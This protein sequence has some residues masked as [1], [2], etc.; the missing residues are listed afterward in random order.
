MLAFGNLPQYDGWE[1]I[2]IALYTHKWY[3]CV[4]FVYRLNVLKS[5]SSIQNDNTCNTST[6]TKDVTSRV[7]INHT[8]G[9]N[10]NSQLIS[11]TCIFTK[12]IYFYFYNGAYQ[13]STAF[14]IWL[15][16]PPYLQ[17]LLVTTHTIFSIFYRV[18]YL[19]K[20]MH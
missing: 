8:H 5:W 3:Y 2:P 13:I 9:I 1:L 7:L 12:Y 11:T 19:L 16:F 6:H 14:W 20:L 18:L 17:T 15:Y 4:N 10:P